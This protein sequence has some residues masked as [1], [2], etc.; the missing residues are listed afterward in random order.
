MA[1]SVHGSV[2]RPDR[3]QSCSAVAGWQSS[4]TG[5]SCLRRARVGDSQGECEARERISRETPDQGGTRAAFTFSITNTPKNANLSTVA[6]GLTFG[7]DKIL[8]GGGFSAAN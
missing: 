8:L 6:G 4:N 7:G 3:G 5:R 1:S 2:P